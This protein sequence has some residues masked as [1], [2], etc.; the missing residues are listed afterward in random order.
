MFVYLIFILFLPF[1]Y[2]FNLVAF[3][4]MYGVCFHFAPFPLYFLSC[5]PFELFFALFLSEGIWVFRICLC[6][7]YETWS[8]VWKIVISATVVPTSE[9]LFAATEWD[10]L[11]EFCCCYSHSHSHSHRI[12]CV[13]VRPKVFLTSSNDRGLK[14]RSKCRINDVI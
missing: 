5:F 11:A 3:G 7:T 9:S 2:L 4:C 8:E 12:F 1:L 6:V 10:F 13:A 14:K